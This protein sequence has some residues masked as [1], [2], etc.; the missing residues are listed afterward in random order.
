MPSVGASGA[1][2]GVLGAYLLLFPGA[3]VIALVP[4]FFW[5][6]FFEIPAIFYLGFWFLSQ[7]LNGT[8]Q[9][10]HTVYSPDAQAAGGV[11]FW[12]HVGGFVTGV[13]LVWPFTAPQPKP[14]RR[15]VDEYY[16]W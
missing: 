4:V 16:P 9:I 7:L 15:Y 8:L 12:A 3:R 1:I 5:P 2:A 10:V 14:R 11:A 6:F 13:L